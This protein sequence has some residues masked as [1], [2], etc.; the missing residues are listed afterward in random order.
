[1]HSFFVLQELSLPLNRLSK[2]LPRSQTA[3][4]D[5]FWCGCRKPRELLL[6]LFYFPRSGS[7]VL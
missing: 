4:L 2:N 1:M 6:S 7:K 3:V 5:G